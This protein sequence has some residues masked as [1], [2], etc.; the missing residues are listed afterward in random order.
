MGRLCLPFTNL[1]GL[2]ILGHNDIPRLVGLTAGHIF[3]KR[4]QAYWK[5]INEGT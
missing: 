4:G 1:Y 2:S 5:K 3:T